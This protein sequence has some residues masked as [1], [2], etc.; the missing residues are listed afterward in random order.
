MKAYPSIMSSKD[1]KVP[2]GLPCIGFYK[3]D[4]S[5]LRW[6]WSKKQGWHKH[7]TRTRLFGADEEPFNAAIPIFME[8]M[9]DQIEKTIRDEVKGIQDFTVYT[10]FFGKNS[11][12]GGH[13]Y[14]D[15]K[16]LKLFDV[17]IPRKGFIV[18]RQMIKLFGNQPWH[19]ADLYHGN[20]NQDL[21]YEV[22]GTGMLNGEPLNEGL[23]C[24]G[25]DPSGQ[26]WMAKIKTE[27]YIQ[28]LKSSLGV[29]W[30]AFSE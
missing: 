6:E 1:R 14:D 21:I 11:F 15:E 26:V 28:R 18:P 13:D 24:K 27:K 9:A 10:E 5:N 4:G 2:M 3:Y 23:V 8:T 12:A 30:E 22:R 25:L 29:G 17:W 20:F 7:G 16:L 19:A